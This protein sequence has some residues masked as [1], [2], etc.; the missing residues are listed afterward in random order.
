[1]GIQSPPLSFLIPPHSSS[2]LIEDTAHFCFLS[3]YV[4][5]YILDFVR[6]NIFLRKCDKPELNDI[7]VDDALYAVT[8]ELYNEKTSKSRVTKTVSGQIFEAFSVVA[9]H[10]FQGLSVTPRRC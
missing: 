5:R 10:V 7:L 9:I 4:V 2:I 1:M 3:V 8:P 6:K